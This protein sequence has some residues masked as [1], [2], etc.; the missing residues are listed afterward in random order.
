MMIVVMTKMMTMIVVMVVVGVVVVVVLVELL[1]TGYLMGTGAVNKTEI[2]R[3][4]AQI[5]TNS[6]VCGGWFIQ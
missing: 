6:P 3:S 1:N 5:N 2:T 4:V